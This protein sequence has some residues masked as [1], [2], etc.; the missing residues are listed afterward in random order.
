MKELNGLKMSKVTVSA[1]RKA[2]GVNQIFGAVK[3]GVLNEKGH[4]TN[5]P[6]EEE[7]REPEIR[8]LFA[9]YSTKS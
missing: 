3:I 7:K 4:S 9:A 1:K 5:S 8:L 2:L 6:S